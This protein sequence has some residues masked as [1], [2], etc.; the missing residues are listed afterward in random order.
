MAHVNGCDLPEDLYYLI[1]KHVWV[2]PA[3]PGLVTIGVTDV[4]QSLAGTIV[5]CTPK[6]AGRTVP[7]GQSL[8]TIESSK[9]VGPVLS[10]LSGEIAEVSEVVRKDPGILNRDPYGAGWLVR[11]KPSN[12]EDEKAGLVTGPEGLEAYRAFLEREDIRCGEAA[13]TG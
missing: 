3:E 6:K 8:A 12:W 13:S 10:P 9:W 5:A 7:R 2:R 4:A 1:E 11:L